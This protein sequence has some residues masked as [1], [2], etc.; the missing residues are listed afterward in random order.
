MDALKYRRFTVVAVMFWL[1][2][3]QENRGFSAYLKD[4]GPSPLRFSV[5][6]AVPASY[7]LPTALVELQKPTNTTEIAVS[8][9]N[10]GQTNAVAAAPTSTPAAN[11]PA[12]SGTDSP[13]KPAPTPSASELLVVSPQMLTEFFRPV[14]EGTNSA[15]AVVVPV[16]TP[17]PVGFNP[18][19]MK[20]PSRATYNTP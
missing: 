3:A 5:A 2:A 7:M 8:A 9:T 10:S 4:T 16:M 17:L 1:F 12:V 20:S 13:A 15:S 6:T 11:A 19:V 14:A 18:P